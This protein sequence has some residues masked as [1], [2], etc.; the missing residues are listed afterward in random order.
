VTNLGLL[1]CGGVAGLVSQTFAYPLETLRHR[2]QVQGFGG[3]QYNFPPNTGVWSAL[4][5]IKRTEGWKGLY[6]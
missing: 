6:R 5:I 2:L 3:R 4:Q 1:T